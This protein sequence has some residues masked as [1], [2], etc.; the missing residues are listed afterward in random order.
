MEERVTQIIGGIMINVNFSVENVMY[1]KNERLKVEDISVCDILLEKKSY[2][3]I[4]VY[5][6]CKTTTIAY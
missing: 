4:F 1:V 3:N 5:N 6:I 2:G